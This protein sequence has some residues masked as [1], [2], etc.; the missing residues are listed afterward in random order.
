MATHLPLLMVGP[1]SAAQIPWG[2]LWAGISPRQARA[3]S[4][5]FF[6][7]AGNTHWTQTRNGANGRQS[8]CSLSLESQDQ[9]RVTWTGASPPESYR[10]VLKHK[11]EL[12]INTRSGGS[13]LAHALFP[14]GYWGSGAAARSPSRDS[15]LKP[16]AFVHIFE[17]GAQT[18]T[19]PGKGGKH[20][21]LAPAFASASAQSLAGWGLVPAGSAGFSAGKLRV[22][23]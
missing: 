3:E 18:S 17:T 16:A 7:A 13:A 1:S 15:C 22:S 11:V 23:S 19:I 14:L 8:I 6:P 10:A 9:Q 5:C 20:L 12:M 4:C 21:G 2:S